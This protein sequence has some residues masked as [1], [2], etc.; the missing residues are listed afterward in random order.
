MQRGRVGRAQDDAT[1]SLKSI[2]G[3]LL[4]PVAFFLLFFYSFFEMTRNLRCL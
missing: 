1:G 4:R 3:D 2:L